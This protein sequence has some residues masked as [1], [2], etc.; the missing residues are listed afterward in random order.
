MLGGGGGSS[1][2]ANAGTG[3]G[4]D[5]VELTDGN[6]RK[7]VLMEKELGWLVEFYAPWCGHCKSLAA[8]WAD[9]ATKL[10]GKMN[11]GALD[12]TQHQST[13]QEYGVQVGNFTLIT[14][15]WRGRG[16]LKSLFWLNC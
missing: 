2:N 3:E 9:A 6:F 16:E 7:K 15:F 1:S 13:A 8:P 11:L 10:K 14:Y 12:A 5:V 4:K